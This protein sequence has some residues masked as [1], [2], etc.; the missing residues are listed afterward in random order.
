MYHRSS[1]SSGLSS[2]A[3]VQFNE[4]PDESPYEF[5]DE[6][7]EEG[8]TL[9]EAAAVMKASIVEAPTQ[10]ARSRSFCSPA[11]INWNFGIGQIFVCS[12]RNGP[13]W[14]ARVFIQVA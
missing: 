2:S 1:N 9:E 5:D 10:F 12:R 3:L 11:Q 4:S 8:V 6:L 13:N 14:A 7:A